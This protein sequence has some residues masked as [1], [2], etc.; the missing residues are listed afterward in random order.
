VTSKSCY[1]FV[2]LVTNSMYNI[3]SF[4]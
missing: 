4:G 1:Y 3:W 2:Y